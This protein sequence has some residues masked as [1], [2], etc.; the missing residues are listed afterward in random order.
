MQPRALDAVLF[1]YYDKETGSM[2]VGHS[3][4]SG[5]PVLAGEKWVMTLWMRRGVSATDRWTSYDPTG[6]RVEPPE[7]RKRRA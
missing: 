3:L 2:D 7:P 1:T 5:C 4:H 6:A